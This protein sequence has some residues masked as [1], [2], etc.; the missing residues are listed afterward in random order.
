MWN[1][2]LL[3]TYE[4]RL[5]Q[6]QYSVDD[7][8]NLMCIPI[9]EIKLVQNNNNKSIFTIQ[10]LTSIYQYYLINND[11]GDIWKFQWSTKGDDYRWIE[12]F[13]L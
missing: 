6:V 10:P 2:I 4:G 9:N 13:L 8:S 3:D 1:F 7:I 12:P 5:W 11:N